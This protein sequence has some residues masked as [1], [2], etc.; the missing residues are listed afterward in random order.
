MQP[1]RCS[2]AIDE[3]PSVK[4]LHDLAAGVFELL[5]HTPVTA[6]GVNRCAHFAMES[7]DAWH[8]LG[9]SLGPGRRTSRATGNRVRPRLA[10]SRLTRRITLEPI[11][12][13]RYRSRHCSS[14]T[15]LHDCAG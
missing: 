3:V 2:F 4:A 12:L 5:P 10:R 14:S 7:E 9:F 13:E 1:E 8:S 6:F 15:W 11:V